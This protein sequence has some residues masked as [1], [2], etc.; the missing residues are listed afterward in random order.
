MYNSNSLRPHGLQ[1]ARPPCPSPSTGACSN[2]SP[3]SWWCHSTISSSVSPFSP[4]LNLSQ[5]QG[6]FQWVSYSHQ[7]GSCFLLQGCS[8]LQGIFPT[9]ESS[10]GLLHCR[11]IL[12]YLS[13]QGSPLRSGYCNS[14]YVDEETEAQ[15]FKCSAQDH[16]VTKQQSQNIWLYI[17]IQS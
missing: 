2:S 13:Y 12:Y 6:L 10:P 15:S 11:Q 5:H 16:M 4:F 7:E 14:H 17:Q 9:Q 3:L 1:H 8:L